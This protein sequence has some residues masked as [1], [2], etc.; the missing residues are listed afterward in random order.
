MTEKDLLADPDYHLLLMLPHDDIF[1]F[2][3]DQ[4]ESRT[5]TMRIYFGINIL[6]LLAMILFS[7]MDTLLEKIGWVDILKQAGLGTLLVLTLLIPVHELIHALAYK[8]VGAP[9][10]SFGVNWRMFYFYAVADGFVIGRRSFAFVGLAPFFVIT[11]ACL[12]GIFFAP[13]LI[14]W[15]LW[16]VLLMHTGACAGDF[17]M[18]SFYERNKGYAEILTFDDVRQKRSYFY[19]KN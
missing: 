17:A 6:I 10:V 18:M 19:V 8:I 15:L 9:R 16:G 7:V 2:V 4:V 13:V 14:K 12:C 11:I 1:P 3:Q 5:V